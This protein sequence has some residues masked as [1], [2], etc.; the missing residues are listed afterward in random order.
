M[1]SALCHSP[2]MPRLL[3]LAALAALA[4]CQPPAAD[5]YV[6]RTRIDSG[7]SGPSEPID[8]PD[9]EGAIW[10]PSGAGDRLLFGKAG[11]RPL[12]AFECV[13]EDGVRVLQYTRFAP[14]DMHA[15]AILALIGNGHVS[16]LKID[17]VR[18]G[19]A[20]LWQ[21]SIAADS[22]MLDVLTGRREVE[23][24]VPGAGSIV[25]SPSPLPGALVERCRD[26]NATPAPV[27]EA[28]RG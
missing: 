15:K 18:H 3:V 12:M 19:G 5:D 25:L 22:P 11:E 4:S 10:A 7:T 26:A 27:P 8:S 6:E 16:R 24:T 14:A 13:I 1:P 20:W 9:T 23:A 2:A 17:A 21:G 28:G